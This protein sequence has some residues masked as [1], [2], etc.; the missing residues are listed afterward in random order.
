MQQLPIDKVYFREVLVRDKRFLKDLYHNNKLQNEKQILG[1][2]EFHLNTLIK[3]FHL[4]LNN[5]IPILEENVEKIKKAKKLPLF[6]QHFRSSKDF[7]ATL[8]APRE[9]K[10]L[11]LKR[12]SALFSFILA[13]LFEE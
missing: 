9:Q 8:E 13:S 2:D 12:F 11:I 10:V 5:T 3:K 1:A 4:I 6:K 7:L